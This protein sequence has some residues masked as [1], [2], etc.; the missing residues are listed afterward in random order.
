MHVDVRG[1]NG[2]S[3]ADTWNHEVQ[4]Q[5]GICMN[6]FP[7]LFMISGPQAP[8]ANIPM[9]IDRA[10][11]WI[12]GALRHLKASGQDRIEA[13]P[14]A[15]RQWTDYVQMLLDA[16]LLSEGSKLHS[17]FLGA[18]IPGK[19]S[20]PL[21]YFGGAPRYFGEIDQEAQAGYPGFEL[22]ASR[23]ISEVA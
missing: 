11:N 22:S 17:W 9:V 4:T 19:K 13:R 14:E 2:Q 3:L 1:R 6:G 12:G 23:V 7:N 18:N 8:F 5:L 16:T 21:F 15:C 10:A 20:A